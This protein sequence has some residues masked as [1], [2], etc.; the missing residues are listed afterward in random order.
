M[1]AIKSEKRGLY[2]EAG[3]RL[4]CFWPRL[5]RWSLN[6]R[7]PFATAVFT[8]LGTGLDNVPVPVHNG[9]RTSGDLVF[10]GGSGAGPLRPDT[11]VSF[12]VHTYAGRMA[13]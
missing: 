3:L 10:E 13:L 11:R 5:M 4:S 9:R 6:R 8:N 2:F 7:W 1:A 12:A